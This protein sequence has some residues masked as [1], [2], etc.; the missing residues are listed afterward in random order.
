MAR[1]QNSLKKLVCQILIFPIDESFYV[2]RRIH[3]YG[4]I[5]DRI[6]QKLI[7]RSLIKL[8]GCLVYVVAQAQT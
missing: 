2:S 8:V 1:R 3:R 4:S 6:M 7:I 5:P